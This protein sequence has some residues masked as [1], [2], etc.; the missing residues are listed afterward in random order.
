MHGLR[1]SGPRDHD[2]VSRRRGMTDGAV[3]NAARVVLRPGDRRRRLFTVV[4]GGRG[5]ADRCERPVAGAFLE[6]SEKQGALNEQGQ[7]Q[8]RSPQPRV[9]ET[10]VDN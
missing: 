3:E 10:F 8:D 7:G 6:I 5:G 1:G 9:P 4:K 2:N